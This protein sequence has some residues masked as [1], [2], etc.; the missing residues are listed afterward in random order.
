[1]KKLSF[2]Y[3]A[4]LAMAVLTGAL[5]LHTSQQVQHA[6]DELRALN[7]A[8]QAEQ[9]T[10][11]YLK[12]EWAYLNTPSRLEY[13]AQEFTGLV[14]PGEGKTQVRSDVFVIKQQEMRAQN[15]VYSSQGLPPKKPLEAPE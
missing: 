4:V 15:I 12:A 3:I 9:E 14:P 6:E 11:D 2:R 8:V 1:M 5:L 7:R 13:L 10:I